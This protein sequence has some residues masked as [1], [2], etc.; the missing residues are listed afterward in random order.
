[1]RL[2]GWGKKVKSN[3]IPST[4]N[5]LYIHQREKKKVKHKRIEKM[6]HA[7]MD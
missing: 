3:Y 4:R 1:M 7:V 6:D 2:S 5:S